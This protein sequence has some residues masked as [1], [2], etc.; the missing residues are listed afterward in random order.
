MIDIDAL[1]TRA[2]SMVARKGLRAAAEA[3][4]LTQDTLARFIVGAKSHNGTVKLVE[5]GLKGRKR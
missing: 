4:G 2:R 1:R 5:E 3:L